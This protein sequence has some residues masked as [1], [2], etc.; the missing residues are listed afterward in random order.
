MAAGGRNE[1]RGGAVLRVMITTS[2]FTT[3]FLVAA[4]YAASGKKLLE[5]TILMQNGPPCYSFFRAPCMSSRLHLARS[6]L[7]TWCSKSYSTLKPSTKH[8]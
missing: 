3:V 8:T 6:E 2:T 7:A 5:L 4:A 1:W